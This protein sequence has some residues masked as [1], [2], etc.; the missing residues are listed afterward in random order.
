[1]P[2]KLSQKA[3]GDGNIQIGGDVIINTVDYTCEI[4]EATKLIKDSKHDE[5]INLLER[6]WLKY[7]DKMTPRQKYRTQANIGH[8]YDQLGKYEDASRYWLK[9]FQYDPD[10]EEAQAR[11][12]WAFLYQ[13]KIPESRKVAELVLAKYPENI[14]ARALWIR[15][16]PEEMT[17]DDLVKQIPEHQRNNTEV[18]MA[19]AAI[20]S[21]KKQ[22]DH[23][24]QYLTQ[25]LRESK[26]H[27]KIKEK[28]AE[29]LLQKSDVWKYELIGKQPTS[30]EK[31][32]ISKAIEYLTEACN[33]YKRNTIH[34]VQAKLAIAYAYR[35][36][37]KFPE[38]EDIIRVTYEL[39]KSNEQ[40]SC[41]YAA[42]LA[43]KGEIDKAI[44]ILS[45]LLI[46]PKTLIII[47]LYTQLLIG[48]NKGNDKENANNILQEHINGLKNTIPAF[49]F[50]Y[51]KQI[52]L[53][54]VQLKGENEAIDFLDKLPDL[55]SSSSCKIL[56]GTALSLGENRDK[57]IEMA[58][59]I[60]REDKDKMTW[61]EKRYLAILL[62]GLGQWEH[63]ITVWKEIVSGEYLSQDLYAILE[64]AR[65]ADNI[66]VIYDYCT[67]L[68]ENNVWDDRIIN[69]ELEYR[70]KYNDNETAT[71]IMQKYLQHC[72][73]KQNADNIRLRLSCLG[74]R[75]HRY[76]LLENDRNKLPDV[77]IA[78]PYNGRLV[79][80]ILSHSTNPLEAVDYAYELWRL[81]PDDENANLGLIG[82]ILMK[83]PELKLPEYDTVQ[84]GV[85][86]LYKEEGIEANT[87]HIIENSLLGNIENSR[88]EYSV[89]H[90][91]S[92]NTI[93]KKKGESFYLV[94]DELQDRKA[95]ILEISSKY[96]YR[97]RKCLEEFPQKFPTSKSL[98]S[99][100]SF[101]PDGTVNL[102]PMKRLSKQG[103]KSNK[104]VMALYDTQFIPIYLLARHRGVSEFVVMSYYCSHPDL[105]IKTCFGLEDE[106]N[107]AV[108]AAMK[109]KTVVL[110]ITAL[111]TLLLMEN[112][113][114]ISIDREIVISEG[115]YNRLKDIE[116]AREDYII[117][118]GF[119]SWEKGRLLFVEK[120]VQQ[121]K[122]EQDKV[123]RFIKLVG[124]HCH[125]RSG[126]ALTTIPQSKRKLSIETI[127]QHNVESMVLAT[128]KD[129][130]FWTDDLT[131]GCIA[132]LE[133]GCK[134]IWSQVLI[135]LF[136]GEK[137]SE[138]NVK[139]YAYGYTFSKIQLADL[140][141]AL[142]S[143]K[144][145]SNNKP[146]SDVLPVF[147]DNSISPESISRLFALFVKHV[148]QNTIEF[149]AQQI[150][151]AVLNELSKRQF[152][153]IIIKA[154]PVDRIFG[155]DCINSYKVKK[156]I[157]YWLR[158][159][160]NNLFIV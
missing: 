83:G 67:Q 65:Q 124:E 98:R 81:H 152:G 27:P 45:P 110:D 54:N 154:L 2:D 48:R 69:L 93:G 80:Q 86:V 106:W 71:S 13:S 88:G 78:H 118:G 133:F 109:T 127:G 34:L 53:L 64:A 36:I 139:L 149:T 44:G 155:F 158:L 129:C 52:V 23:A 90:C 49:C 15:T 24:E 3:E 76:D 7:N 95:T 19:L 156:V 41:E 160:D 42:L 111:M 122:S 6:I 18:L 148:W 16:S 70:E 107:F 46:K 92:Q 123:K 134:R 72:D 151:L 63:A 39:D 140:I 130:V 96:L 128:G 141:A 126:A 12:A 62:Q 104:E 131:L 66:T 115:T 132:N 5:A 14:L 105:K 125:I 61:H 40:S 138:L 43:N 22:W 117:E 50:A 94:R 32:L 11:K 101:N 135:N 51:I 100:L 75:T 26:G 116:A 150:M 142:E 37:G 82:S 77:T 144:W 157:N 87:G 1:M 91:I 56:K 8:A 21:E 25:A 99:F 57:S 114:W 9:A 145:Q 97:F 60:C 89:S 146:F 143:A 20:S 112:D 47:D 68:R 58:I 147:S 74:I 38:A 33:E 113:F 153:F 121:L 84:P 159:R 31:E 79:V 10:Y 136:G 28:L 29:L 73:K 85:A 120:N 17:L 4:D 35:G 137:K 119:V 108:A 102:E 30:H 59:A 55:L 103:E